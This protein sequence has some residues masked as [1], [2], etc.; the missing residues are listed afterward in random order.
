MPP[1]LPLSLPRSWYHA[2][3]WC[4]GTHSLLWHPLGQISSESGVQQSDHLGPLL[5][6]LVPH[7]F[8]SSLDAEDECANLILQPWYLDYVALAG[9]R[10]AV[11]CA[12]HLIEE[13]GSALGLHVNLL[14]CEL[15]KDNTSILSGHPWGPNPGLPALHKF[16]CGK[17]AKSR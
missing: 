14:K 7:K 17:C 2:V 9:R 6:A 13:M 3:S 8:V 5:L 11:L 15:R 10:T 1:P 12:L 4:Y 16:I